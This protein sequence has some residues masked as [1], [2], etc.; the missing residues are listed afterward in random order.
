M[1]L[2]NLIFLLF[3]ANFPAFTQD[4]LTPI[5]TVN[6]TVINNK[7]IALL[8]PPRIPLASSFYNK[9]MWQHDWTPVPTY[10]KKNLS[11]FG[12][13]DKIKTSGRTIIYDASVTSITDN[14]TL[15]GNN[16]IRIKQTRALIEVDGKM[17]EIPIHYA[18]DNSLS[19]IDFTQSEKELITNYI[20]KSLNHSGSTPSEIVITARNN[21]F[22]I[23]I[24]K[25]AYTDEDFIIKG[26][27]LRSRLAKKEGIQLVN[28]LINRG[29]PQEASSTLNELIEKYSEDRAINK[30][31]KK[32]EEHQYI[33]QINQTNN[34]IV[35]RIV[36][37]TSNRYTFYDGI[38]PSGLAQ[39]MNKQPFI[40]NL[41]NSIDK[42]TIGVYLDVKGMGPVKAKGF[43]SAIKS[44]LNAIHPDIVVKALPQY[45]LNTKAL[46]EG[47]TVQQVPNAPRQATITGTKGIKKYLLNIKGKQEKV[48]I[49][50]QVKNIFVAS[51]TKTKKVIDKFFSFFDKSISKKN[52]KDWVLAKLIN[53]TRKKLKKELNVSDEDYDCLIRHELAQNDIVII[54]LHQQ[55]NEITDD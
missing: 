50:V 27:N 31:R 17:L 4:F 33:R 8:G 46:L 52:H 38:N 9:Y 45:D 21:D 43:V 55:V 23:T 1:K 13:Y 14:A 5:Y 19:S 26:H 2:Y 36:E 16:G 28:E 30:L 22:N 6:S 25:S 53:N 37:E 42:N 3:T 47:K 10:N 32:I 48:A 40:T 29:N 20:Q 44:Q 39:D 7:Q 18:G 34:G 54:R 15:D 41:I 11:L 51:K 24:N 12:V 49:I 35:S